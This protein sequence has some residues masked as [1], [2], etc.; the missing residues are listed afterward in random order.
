MGAAAHGARQEG[1]F[2]HAERQVL[3]HLG[4]NELRNDQRGDQPVEDLR[5]DAVARRLFGWHQEAPHAHCTWRVYQESA[6]GTVVN[7]P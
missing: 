5:R 4:E 2:A 1:Q 6:M 7:R 3:L